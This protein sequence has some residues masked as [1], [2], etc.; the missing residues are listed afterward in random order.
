MKDD[1]AA[2]IRECTSQI[3]TVV[4]DLLTDLAETEN[5]RQGVVDLERSTAAD[6]AKCRQQLA[7]EAERAESYR[8]D[9]AAIRDALDAPDDA[10]IN[11][12]VDV[13]HALTEQVEKADRLPEPDHTNPAHW[14]FSAD[15]IAS[16][17][18]FSRFRS[19][20]TLVAAHLR[21]EAD[22]L[23]AAQQ[24]ADADEEL[25]EKAAMTLAFAVERNSCGV[26]ESEMWKECLVPE[27]RDRYLDQA[28]ALLAANLLRD[29]GEK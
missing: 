9:V 18:G 10:D 1:P 26:T 28:S 27:S 13:V 19:D 24:Q 22:R 21:R 25:I 8:L 6:L 15:V 23:E 5:A 2:L 29:G 11:E 4:D 14:R 3:R 17:D 12:L 16:A 20:D 7:Q